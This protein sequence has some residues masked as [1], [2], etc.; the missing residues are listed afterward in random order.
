M[1]SF[2]WQDSHRIADPFARGAPNVWPAS[3]MARGSCPV[4]EP[5]ST[6]ALVQEKH[7]RAA[8]EPSGMSA[9][10]ASPGAF[11]PNGSAVRLAR[12]NPRRDF[13][14][15]VIPAADTSKMSRVNPAYFT[16]AAQVQRKAL[17]V[18]PSVHAIA[19][20]GE[21]LGKGTSP[22]ASLA[23]MDQNLWQLRRQMAV[24]PASLRSAFEDPYVATFFH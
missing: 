12:R 11:W 4:A 20:E 6:C 18:N 22:A 10:L 13:L 7:R 8:L 24:D 9:A 1:S 15:A 5:D 2:A 14:P 23:L 16:P 21:L 19:N 3:N 17:H